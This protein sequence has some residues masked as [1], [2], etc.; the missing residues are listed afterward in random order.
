M[1]FTPRITQA[2][3][4]K[5]KGKRQKAEGKRKMDIPPLPSRNLAERLFAFAL[6]IIRLCQELQERPGVG[7]MVSYQLFKAGTSIGA[8]YEEAQAGQSRADFISKN[9]ICLKEAR[10]TF[11]WWRLLVAAEI[12]SLDSLG[13]LLAESEQITKIFGSIVCRSREKC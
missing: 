7:R 6:R 5:E 2:C 8:N 1:P 9:A 10:E 13:G 3:R 4:V 11:Y 12:V